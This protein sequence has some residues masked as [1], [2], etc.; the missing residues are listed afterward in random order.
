MNSSRKH[1]S[2]V[3]FLAIGAVVVASSLVLAYGVKWSRPA[4]IHNADQGNDLVRA[5][6]RDNLDSGEW[7][8]VR[9][10]PSQVLTGYWDADI[11]EAEHQLNSAAADLAR[12]ANPRTQ[13]AVAAAK[14]FL[15]DLKSRKNPVGV[16]LK[17]RTANPS[18]ALEIRD[19]LFLLEDSG[20][21]ILRQFPIGS[22]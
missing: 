13:A 3:F 1:R 12:D 6:L 22:E 21:R 10:W 4:Q 15:A 2:G 7:E 17:Y 14:A 8:E 16:R 20:I 19:Q 9:W 5:W 18:G 11:Q